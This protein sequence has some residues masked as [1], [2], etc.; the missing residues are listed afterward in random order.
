[1]PDLPSSQVICEGYTPWDAQFDFC[2]TFD[3]TQNP[4]L[5][6]DSFCSLAHSNQPPV[7]VASRPQYFGIDTAP[8][9]PNYQAYAIRPVS[10]SHFNTLPSGMAARV[11]QRFPADPISFFAY[12]SRQS[13]G[14]ALNYHAKSSRELPGQ[15]VL[16]ISKRSFQI[17]KFRRRRVETLNHSP[18]FIDGLLYQR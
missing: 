2:T 16:H 14:L 11:H 8:I 15:L 7:A 1:M 4:K 18:A 10:D 6:L 5:R 9:I 3:T 12:A 13:P 17:R